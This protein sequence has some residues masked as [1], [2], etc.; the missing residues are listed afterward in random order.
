SLHD[1]LPISIRPTLQLLEALDESVTDR[2]H[3]DLLQV[4]H[5]EA[6]RTK[7]SP[8][9]AVGVGPHVE[10]D[11]AHPPTRELVTERRE[12]IREPAIEQRW[13]RLEVIAVVSTDHL[14]RVEAQRG[15]G[16]G[17]VR[18]AHRHQTDDNHQHQPGPEPAPSS[19]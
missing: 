8:T 4:E 12:A 2:I 15:T 19:A 7:R 17:T 10:L 1:A 13:R 18:A 14:E 11:L 16:A 3:V 9:R 5:L 6:A